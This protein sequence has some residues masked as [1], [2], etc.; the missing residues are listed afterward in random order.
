MTERDVRERIVHAI[1]GCCEQLTGDP[2]LAQ[3]VRNNAQ[4]APEKKQRVSAVLILL[5]ALIF[6]GVAAAAAIRWGAFDKLLGGNVPNAGEVM[7]G[8]L[9][10]ETVNGVEITIK[11]A[12]Y[13]GRTLWLT[14]SYRMPDMTEPLGRRGDEG[15]PAEWDALL[16]AHNVGWWMDA[17]WINGKEVSMPG[18]SYSV[19]DGSD[20]PGEL[21]V[22]EAW[23]L[24][25]EGVELQGPTSIALPI[26]DRQSVRN[27]TKAEHPELYQADGTRR[28]P[29]KGVVSFSFT[30]NEVGILTEHPCIQAVL[31]LVTAQVS[32]VC[33]S[34][35]MT[36]VTMALEVSPEAMEAFVQEHGSAMTLT[37]EGNGLSFVYEYSAMDV[38]G[39]WVCSL[40]LVDGVGNEVFPALPDG[41][42]LDGYGDT[43]AEWLFPYRE[44]WPEEM[45]LAP[46]QDGKADM[47][48][49][50]RVR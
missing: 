20:V 39:Q 31:P 48:L 28:Q 13:D 26:G 22:H 50:V 18:G 34:P 40:A 49:A 7:Q 35:I 37:D 29:E 1:D 5:L 8:Y 9:H 41:Y 16:Q 42:G 46:M 4:S 23:R 3:R 14:T 32:D 25:N 17:M 11:E 45:Y 10:Q 44:H 2:W 21:L 27:F 38:F 24:D 6:A 15:W 19:W 43:R 30:P 47:Q 33:Y 36:Y 12:G